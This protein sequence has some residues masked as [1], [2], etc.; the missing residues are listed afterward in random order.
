MNGERAARYEDLFGD[1][2]H[3]EEEASARYVD[4]FERPHEHVSECAYC[5]VCATIAIVRRTRPEI[6]DHLAGAARELVL[7]AGLLIEEAAKIVG[8][9]GSDVPEGGEVHSIRRLDID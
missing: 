7:A 2:E 8:A 1:G 5:P 6:L 3:R 4:L 9:E